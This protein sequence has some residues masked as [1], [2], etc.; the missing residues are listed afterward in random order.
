MKG[1]DVSQRQG[2]DPQRFLR[3]NNML[4]IAAIML[5]VFLTQSSPTELGL[6]SSRS[7]EGREENNDASGKW[8]RSD[9]QPAMFNESTIYT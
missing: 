1:A 6:L 9:I 8:L 7:V 5:A 3:N 4:L 2:K